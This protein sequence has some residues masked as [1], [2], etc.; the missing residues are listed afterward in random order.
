MPVISLFAGARRI[1]FGLAACT[2]LTALPAAHAQ[3][4]PGVTD[5][6][7]DR[8]S[9]QIQRPIEDRL[10]NLDNVLDDLP[11]RVV[12]GEL[13]EV[14]TDRVL[15][16]DRIGNTLDATREL[17][18]GIVSGVRETVSQV[19]PR[20][21]IEI[22]RFGGWPVMR[23]EWIVMLPT[24][25]VGELDD[26]S[27]DVLEQ[28]DLGS[29]SQTLLVV[30]FPDD[31][32]TRRQIEAEL[33]ALDGQ[34]VE[35]NHVFRRAALDDPQADMSEDVRPAAAPMTFEG[36]GGGLR[37]GM[38]D[39]DIE[40]GHP[41]LQTLEL[42]EADFVSHGAL[43]PTGHGTS[44]ASVLSRHATVQIS[45]E[46]LG[47]SVFFLDSDG[48][49][50]ATTAS[51][52]EAIDWMIVEGVDLINFSL[53]GPPNAALESMI[54]SAQARG[55]VVVAAVGNEG[56]A[57]GPLY[58]AAYDGVIG[59]TAVNAN[60]VPY[61]WANRGPYVDIAAEGVN[62]LVAAP[63]GGEQRDSGTSLAA[64]IVSAF[65]AGWVQDA[66]FSA[67]DEAENRLIRAVGW[68]QDQAKDE[69]IGYGVL[70]IAPRKED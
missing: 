31:P 8:L 60:G 48:T 66:E 38:V 19:R 63:D 39:T 64:P 33:S 29:V 51:L 55:I 21:A 54:Q 4:L 40:E 3:L 62:V 70:M 23:N 12:D 42:T 1:G 61:R 36:A 57:S 45:P 25:A 16:S 13:G 17:T 37:I 35:R 9:D 30:Q 41:L 7:E 24:V 58:P 18:G 44:V 20:R 22:D 69:A 27:L 10:Q 11:E 14:L 5:R 26:L 46:L 53:T 68:T 6:V 52:I 32:T 65:L 47:A 56:P 50:G 67:V 59:V 28:T 43:R 2:C 49:T 15:S 34:I